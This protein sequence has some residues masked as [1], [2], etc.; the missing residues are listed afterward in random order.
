M[1]RL[2]INPSSIK[3]VVISH[4]YSNHLGK[5]EGFLERNSNVTVFIPNSFPQSI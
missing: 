5:L 2:G 3:K 4:I 1:K